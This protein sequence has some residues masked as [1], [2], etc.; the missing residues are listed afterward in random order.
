MDSV[1]NNLIITAPHC[2][3]TA[4]LCVLNLCSVL[5]ECSYDKL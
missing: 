4:I 3:Y 2:Q 1:V 5:A